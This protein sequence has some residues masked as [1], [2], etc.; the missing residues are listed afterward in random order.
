MQSIIETKFTTPKF[1]NNT[2]KVTDT[3]LDG[4]EDVSAT[5]NGML[6]FCPIQPIKIKKE[7]PHELQLMIERLNGVFDRLQ[8]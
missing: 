2:I 8:H 5:L 4:V 1:E 7:Y 6:Y 3:L